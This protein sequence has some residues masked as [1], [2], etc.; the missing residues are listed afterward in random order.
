MIFSPRRQKACSQAHI[1][2]PPITMDLR[3]VLSKPKTLVC[4]AI[5]LSLT[6]ASLFTMDASGY[7]GVRTGLYAV[8]VQ[9]ILDVEIT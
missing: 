8:Q 4:E 5:G 3:G 7:P 1:S 9:A 6:V 2:L